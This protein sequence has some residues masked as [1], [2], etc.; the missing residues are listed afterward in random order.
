M[1]ARNALMMRIFLFT[2]CAFLDYFY[3]KPTLGSPSDKHRE[4]VFVS[5][6]GVCVYL[7]PHT[8]IIIS[9]MTVIQCA[10]SRYMDNTMLK[11]RLINKSKRKTG[12]EFFCVCLPLVCRVVLVLQGYSLLYCI[13]VI[14]LTSS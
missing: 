11:S 6:S 12:D 2:M 10:A 1:Y 3:Y 4:N 14:S 13:F 7:L 9:S 8:H 5:D